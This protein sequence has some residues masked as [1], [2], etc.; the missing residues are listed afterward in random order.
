M[1]T[2][3]AAIIRPPPD[4]EVRTGTSKRQ[5]IM[6]ASLVT[7]WPLKLKMTICTATTISIRRTTAGDVPEIADMMQLVSGREHSAEAVRTMTADFAPGRFY[8]W[9]AFAGNE[10]AGLTT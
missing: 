4:T 9:L 2:T 1:G 6:M 3:I 5:Y 7:A 10:P 8:G